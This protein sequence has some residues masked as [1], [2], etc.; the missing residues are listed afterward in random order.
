MSLK[1]LEG[2]RKEITIFHYNVTPLALYEIANDVHILPRDFT[3]R[4][5]TMDCLNNAA[6]TL[7]P[8]LVLECEITDLCSRGGIAKF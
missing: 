1:S 7:G 5:D 4:E 3:I 2:G 6:E 8:F